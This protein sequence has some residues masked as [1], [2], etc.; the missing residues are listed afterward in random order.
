MSVAGIQATDTPSS[1]KPVRRYFL[2]APFDDMA[3]ES[4]VDLIR[5]SRQPTLFRYVV[6][7]NVDHV[8]RLDGDRVLAQYYDR[9][10]MSLCDSRPIAA[11]ARL[12]SLDLPL[13][14]GSDLTVRL[15]YS[16]IRDG[17]RVTLIAA[18]DL[19]VRDMELAFPNV[20]F[21]SLVPPAGVLNDTAALQACVEFAAGEASRF[22]F[23]AI[24]SPQS[25]KIAHA[26]SM[27]SDARG[28]GFCVGASLE[29][30]VGAKKRAPLWMRRI[31]MEWAHR[32]ASDPKRLW[33]R[34]VYAVPRLLRLL[35]S[36]V[37]GR[38]SSMR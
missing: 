22:I 12:M 34:Y 24:G 15:F 9:A 21:R 6:T 7:P 26:L 2:G 19:I 31:G 36:E 4:V 10:W 3:Q 30:L 25:E 27:R 17:D 38:R 18:N 37:I 16:V 14:T 35:S 29:F 13:V 5:D 33:R 28:I 32:L 1:A 11:L 20:R 23:I 8:V